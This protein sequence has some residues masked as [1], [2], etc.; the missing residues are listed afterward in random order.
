MEADILP[1]IDPAL[2]KPGPIIA[3]QPEPATL[4]DTALASFTPIESHMRTLAA[5]Y[6]DVAYDVTTPKGM[7]DAKAARLVL[8]E[9]GRF[10]VQRLV[11]RLKDEA[12]DLKRVVEARA[13]EVIALTKPVEDA[14]H[15][16]IEAEEARVAA[17][18]AERARIEAERIEAL[19]AKLAALSTW[20]ERCRAPGMT[21]ERIHNGIRALT[22]LELAPEDWQEFHA[23]A[24]AR[25]DEVLEVMRELHRQAV[26]REQE[27][28]ETE[29]LRKI[30][31][32]QAA[33]LAEL[34]AKERQRAASE[35]FGKAL[36]SAVGRVGIDA[37][38]AA[39]P[40]IEGRTEPFTTEEMEQHAAMLEALQ[41][42]ITT[43]PEQVGGQVDGCRAPESQPDGCSGPVPQDQTSLPA[44]PFTQ[45][46]QES[47]SSPADAPAAVD[48]PRTCASS[49]AESA[50]AVSSGDEGPAAHADES[51][52]DPA[53][54]VIATLTLGA[55]CDWLGF[56]LTEAFIEQQLGIK[57]AG[58]AQ[59]AVLFTPLQRELIRSRLVKHL[60]G[61]H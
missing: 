6:R 19:Q 46:A 5:R 10:A 21:A 45:D 59:R 49:T 32:Q 4:K 27:A 55:I 39:L 35:R 14:I 26:A 20:I 30:A 41:P 16:Q 56:K 3:L 40:D 7:K 1:Q 2:L 44:S 11:Q 22:E 58:R 60:E 36:A 8:R 29:R 61:L 12:N 47:G 53:P 38:T 25:K 13:T 54:P 50:E 24:L 28:A 48:A 57:P 43:P 15:Q 31:E 18:K 33:E 51:A 9:E 42:R 52:A 23:R 34:R 37:V 17:E